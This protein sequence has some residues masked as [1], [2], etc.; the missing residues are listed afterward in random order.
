M[1]NKFDSFG[2]QQAFWTSSTKLGVGFGQSSKNNRDN[3]GHAELS[4]HQ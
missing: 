3:H 2:D 4:G 1:Y